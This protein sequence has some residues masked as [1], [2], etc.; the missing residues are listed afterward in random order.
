[1]RK[2]TVYIILG[3]LGIVFVLWNMSVGFAFIQ[4]LYLFLC[5]WLIQKGYRNNK[6]E[7]RGRRR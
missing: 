5:G 4:L 2:G 7:E 3:I 1:M 6:K